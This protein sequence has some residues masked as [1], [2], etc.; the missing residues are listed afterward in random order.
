MLRKGFLP[1]K[2]LYYY[3]QTVFR[4]GRVLV[5]VFK[6]ALG[7]YECVG[8]MKGTL[9]VPSVPST[10][11]IF[12]YLTTLYIHIP[13]MISYGKAALVLNKMKFYTQ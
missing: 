6:A 5:G 4:G 11:T 7:A 1:R 9:G 2:R 3:F 8:K 10:M 12:T 13:H